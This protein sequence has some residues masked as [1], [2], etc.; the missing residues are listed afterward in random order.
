M[1]ELISLLFTDFLFELCVMPSKEGGKG[2]GAARSLPSL[3]S[4]PHISVNSWALLNSCHFKQCV[5]G[6]H[7]SPLLFLIYY[8]F[9]VCG[10]LYI[11][12]CHC[13]DV[14]IFLKPFASSTRKH[15]RFCDA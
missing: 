2:V 10:C 14:L 9:G 6:M 3:Q 4:P 5:I 8:Y 11:C 1:S 13:A 15:L 12:Y 7:L